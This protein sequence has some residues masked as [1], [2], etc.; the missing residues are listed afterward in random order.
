MPPKAAGDPRLLA[1]GYH[2][3]PQ[4]PAPVRG[5][6]HGQELVQYDFTPEQYAALIKLTAAPLHRVFPRIA[7][8]YPRDRRGRLLT[9]RLPAAQQAGFRGVLGH[10]HLQ[11]NK[12]DPGP[13]FQWDPV[14]TGA[15]RESEQE[16]QGRKPRI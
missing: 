15:R 4:R 2:G 12:V 13:A 16:K 7:L 6:I 9:D 10:F 8:D 5:R 11:E 14:I 3:R 1:P